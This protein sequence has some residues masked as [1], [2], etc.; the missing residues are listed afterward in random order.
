MSKKHRLVWAV[1]GGLGLLLP[2]ACGG[3]TSGPNVGTAA[4]MEIIEVSNGFGRLLPYEI[5]RVDPATNQPTNE[6]VS[7]RTQ[8]TLQA[9]AIPGNPILPPTQ[10]KTTAVLPNN[11]PGNHFVYARFKN[12]ILLESVLNAASAS[13][14]DQG[15]IQVVVVDPILGTSTDVSGV[16][17]VGGRTVRNGEVQQWVRAGDPDLS[18]SPDDLV[19]L[20]T[21]IGG[22]TP[23]F[24]FPGTVGAG[25]A[26]ASILVDDATFVFVADNDNNLGT[27]DTFPLGAQINIRI[28]SSVTATNGNQLLSPGVASSTVGGDLIGPEVAQSPP[29]LSIPNILPGN[30]IENVD[31]ETKVS[32]SFTEPVQ[33]L[34]IGT[35]VDPPSTSSAVS[36][37]FLAG[38][39][40]VSVPF[41]L[42]APS[43][44]D[45]TNFNLIPAFPLPGAPP[46][47]VS[48]TTVEE[49]NRITVMVNTN[50]TG[51]LVASPNMNTLNA[52]TSFMTGAGP[53]VI[54]APVAPDT[55][56]LGRGGSLPTI[57]VIDLNGFGQG[58]GTPVFDEDC[59]IKE[60]ST[61]FPNNPNVS[62]QGAL[63]VPP[64]QVGTSTL[65]GGSEG[66]FTLSKDSNL[67]SRLLS[68]NLVQAVGD[69][70]IGHA[71]DGTFNNGPPPFGCQA[72]GGNLCASSAN[73]LVDFVRAGNVLQPAG[74][75]TGA[76]TSTIIIGAEN[77][78]SWSPHPNPPPL[79]F[80]PTCLSPYIAGQEPTSVDALGLDLIN[81]GALVSNLLGPSQGSPLGIPSQC[82][83]PQGLLTPEQNTFFMGPSLPST[84][85]SSCTSYTYRQQIGHF[86]YV[87]DR[88]R[89]E[90]LVINSNRFTLIDR[91]NVPDP[92][93]LAMGPNVDFLAVSNRA[94]NSVS[95][96]DIR[97]AS[98]TFH[99][100]VKTT[101]VG[102][103]PTGIAWDTANEDII[104]TNTAENTISI[105][106]AFGFTVRKTVGSQLNAPFEVA[107]TPRQLGF[108]F[109]RGV[110]FGWILNRN[111]K[112]SIFESGPDGN[113]GRGFDTII[114]IAPFDFPNPRAIRHDPSYLFGGVWVLH[115]DELG[116]GKLSNLVIESATQG[117]IPLTAAT[118]GGGSKL[119]D[120]E[121]A[122]RNVIDA[123][124]L[125]GIPVDIA[126]D[127]QRNL[128]GLGNIFNQF[129]AGSPLN[130]NGKSYVKSDG[131]STFSSYTPQFM[132]LAVPVSSEGPG[133]VDV[134]SLD[135]FARFDTNPF[136]PGIQSIQ[137]SGVNVLSDYFRQ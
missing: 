18:E 69:I 37:Q 9:N 52:Q 16:A 67:S 75:G 23:G 93:S 32:I 137:A 135:N 25:F 45:L 114:G 70:M 26:G 60:G 44:Y 80:P 84:N 61:N 48:G 55:I 102:A 116:R 29:P 134:I 85:I 104:V 73:K 113:N 13:P 19:A 89:S 22:S 127:N 43:V 66:V 123:D 122:I 126:F 99:Q 118:L 65:D 38:G 34:T 96:I 115:E 121:F 54:N 5:R 78:I 111:G 133:V 20:V 83:P 56:Y 40:T 28:N 10:W 101:A 125:T 1:L 39:N 68:S 24:G 82:V 33:P 74:L 92:T 17:F 106:S 95:F 8:A 117:I 36:I 71:L 107:I 103:G 77:L 7:I 110:Y 76:Q 50:Q 41:R 51:D 59:P 132:F 90:V 120:L 100:V 112:V 58:T 2:L 94:A 97:P 3:G 128:A 64:L 53:G 131:I 105:I 62:T 129:S 98:S 86:L 27:Y 63:L 46:E 49:Q 4:Q 31:P 30:S 11:A 47:G 12:D 108:G 119:R 124:Q 130:T 21:D 136:V 79:A 6:V 15:G 91:I 35:L 57:S 88:V 81:G 14:L 72:E 42:E 109:A 87:V